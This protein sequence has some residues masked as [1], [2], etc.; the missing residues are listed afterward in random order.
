[1]ATPSHKCI[2]KPVLTGADFALARDNGWADAGWFFSRARARI[3]AHRL[4]T[5]PRKEQDG[6]LL[7]AEE[8]LQKGSLP[9]NTAGA[10][11]QTLREGMKA[12]CGVLEDEADGTQAQVLR[13]SLPAPLWEGLMSDQERLDLMEQVRHE[14]KHGMAESHE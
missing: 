9:A 11:L 12:V 5:L 14:I 13:T 7:Q 2:S 6:R 1:M 10:W 3:I 8:V 4:Q